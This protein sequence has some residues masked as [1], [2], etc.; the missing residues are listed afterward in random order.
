MENS[1]ISHHSFLFFYFLFK[2]IYFTAVFLLFLIKIQSF[3]SS[4]FMMLSFS[5][6]GSA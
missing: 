5:F 3:I 4:L 2:N 6:F 1:S